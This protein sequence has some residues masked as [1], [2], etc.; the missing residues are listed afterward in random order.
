MLAGFWY[1]LANVARAAALT[2]VGDLHKA[3]VVTNPGA[4]YV[5]V[6]DGSVSLKLGATDGW[7]RG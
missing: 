6:L 7:S 1:K 2:S 3:T 4:D 5:F